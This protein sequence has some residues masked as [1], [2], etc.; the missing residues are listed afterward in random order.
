M[1]FQLKLL[2]VVGLEILYLGLND[3]DGISDVNLGDGVLNEFRISR[4]DV[5]FCCAHVSFGDLFCGD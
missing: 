3:V 4:L 1:H 5:A 2:F